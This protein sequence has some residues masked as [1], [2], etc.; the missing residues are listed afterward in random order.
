MLSCIVV[1]HYDHVVQFEVLLPHLLAHGVPLIVVDDAS[2]GESFNA[3]QRLLDEYTEDTTLIRHDVNLG[4]GAAVMSGL[5]AG[6]AAGYTHAL[7]IDADGQ[8]DA[9]AISRFQEASRQNPGHIICGN[10]IFAED[11]PK[12]R[13]F[14]RYITLWFCW[15]ESLSTEIRDA[16]CGF[17]LYPIDTLVEI[18]DKSNPG[19]RMAFDPEILVRAIWNGVRLQFIPVDVQ[20]PAGGRSHFHY[21]RDNVEIFWM[22]TR[23]ITGMLLRLPTLLRRGRSGHE[24][25]VTR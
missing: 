9:L 23:L 20:Y 22:H 16:M 4:K 24:G 12:L 21:F 3:L 25:P 1:P 18:I 15:L 8:H 14:A 6:R 11:I 17:R 13:F 19:R 7:Q 5:R 10:P 2:P